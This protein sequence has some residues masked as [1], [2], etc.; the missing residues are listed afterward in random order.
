MD[1]GVGVAY[2]KGLFI[3]HERPG[4]VVAV[5]CQIGQQ[6]MSA[7]R[8]GISCDGFLERLTRKCPTGSEKPIVSRIVGRA[9]ERCKQ[10]VQS[11]IKFSKVESRYCSIQALSYREL[12]LPSTLKPLQP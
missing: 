11:S 3:F 2:R 10:A 8:I 7:I 4:R 1:F 9:M 6:Q 5:I 12:T